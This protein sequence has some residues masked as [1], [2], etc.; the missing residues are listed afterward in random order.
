MKYIDLIENVE[1][2]ILV[3]G[4]KL[5]D[6]ANE[7]QK[8]LT[9][10]STWLEDTGKAITVDM[11]CSRT[12]FNLKFEDKNFGDPQIKFFYK[13]KEDKYFNKIKII[14]EIEYQISFQ[15]HYPFL[16]VA[17][18]EEL[19]DGWTE[20]KRTIEGWTDKHF[21]ACDFTINPALNF[22]EIYL[23]GDKCE[24]ELLWTKRDDKKTMY[25]TFRVTPPIYKD[26]KSVFNFNAAYEKNKKKMA[27]KLGKNVKD[28]T[29]FE[30]DD[31]CYS[32]GIPPHDLDIP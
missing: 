11:S 31:V 4:C 30:L 17:E 32:M 2:E 9:Q 19:I 16:A 28:L 12:R 20:S 27:Y 29:S 8:K 18:F 3:A 21:K 5:G 24:V 23:E 7:A 25:I 13:T 10:L 15:N 22:N 6:D 26:N 14:K 1:G